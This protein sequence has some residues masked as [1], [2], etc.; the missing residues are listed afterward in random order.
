MKRAMIKQTNIRFCCALC[1]C[2]CMCVC[3][4]G[5]SPDK[6][7]FRVTLHRVLSFMGN[8]AFFFFYVTDAGVDCFCKCADRNSI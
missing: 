3:A 2:A 7:I 6:I 5:V 1:V 8:W 4:A